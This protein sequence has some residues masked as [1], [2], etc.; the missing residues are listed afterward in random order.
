LSTF[1]KDLR[2]AARMLAKSP[3]FTAAAVIC[4]ALGIGATSAIFSVV[5]AVLLRPLGYRDPGRLVRLYTEFPKFPNGGLRRFWISPPE[6]DELKR[7][8]TSWESLDAWATSGVNL[9]GAAQPIR[10][11]GAAVT[12]GLFTSLGVSPELG[13][14]ITP[15]DDIPGAPAVVVISHDL[16]QRLFAGDR[17]VIGRVIQV[18]GDNTNIVGVMPQSFSFPP[19]EL[20]PPEVWGPL[21]LPAPDPRRR[22]SHFL[23][24]IGRLKTGVP[25]TRAMDEI[26]RHVEQST[27]RIGPKNHPFSPDAHPIVAYGLQDEVVRTIRPALWTLMGAV[28][29]VLLIAC[30][31]VANLLLARAEARQR[32]IAVRKA[33]G[34]GTGLLIRQFTTEGLLLSLGGAALG[35]ALAMAGL[36]VMI[37]AG[38]A[39]IPRATEVG[40]DPT[41]LAVTVGVSLLTALFFGLA[42]LA[43]IAGGTLHDAL[44]AAG[45]RGAAGSVASNRFRSALVSS[46]LALALVLL[47]GT[48]LMIRA[49]WKLSEVDPGYRP[50]NLLTLRLNLPDTVYPK[51]QNRARFWQSIQEKISAIPGVTSATAMAGLPPERPINANDTEIEKFTPVPG[52]PGHNIDYW[53][54]VGDHFF[55]TMGTRLLDGRLFD[56]RDVDGAPPAVIIN[57]TMARTYYGN[58]SPIGRR[59]RP[60]FQDPW[61]TIV[62]VVE[63]VKNAGLDKPAG[64]ELFLPQRQFGARG[65]VYLALRTSGDPHSLIGAVRAAVRDIDPSLPLAQVRTMDEVLAG[66]RSRPRFLTTLLGLFSGAALLLAAVG[67]YGVISYSVTRRMTEFGIRMAMGARAGDVLRLVLTQGLKLA[68]VGVLAGAAGA[69]ALTRVISGLLFG[70]SSFDPLTFCSMALLLG[71]VTVA[72]CIIPAMRATRVDPLIALRYE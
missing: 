27:D 18:D 64:T 15:Q 40:I 65:T 71:A 11:A 31:N 38:K 66:A 28:A 32:E 4:L 25:L 48:G 50:E 17:G 1:F 14:A 35:L 55:D 59:V 53:Q 2:Y 60:G 37:A 21:Q 69:L 70:V 26:K 41:V 61:Y 43:Q 63:D 30:V 54:I 58:E 6:Y 8:L 10:V 13:R 56:A 3:G 23:S 45:G 36:K 47:I 33:L 72:A 16:W 29:F 22:G 39:S 20:D 68:A 34:A 9:A 42:P 57:R 5:H 49:F 12:G 19:G 44:K 46:E 62:G 7:E 24:L 52:G 67:L 51:A